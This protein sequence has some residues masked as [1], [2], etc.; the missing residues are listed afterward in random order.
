MAETVVFEYAERLGVDVGFGRLRSSNGLW[1]P[2]RRTIILKRG[3]RAMLER[4]V[5]A[6]E[7]GHV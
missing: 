1:V 4:S 6:H 5:L 7:L 3:M 2:E